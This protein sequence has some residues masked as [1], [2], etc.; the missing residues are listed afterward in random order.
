MTLVDSNVA[1]DVLT[2]DPAWLDWSVEALAKRT[3]CGALCINEVIYAE[4]S[5]RMDS[6]A[7]LEEALARLKLELTRIPR[8]AL[9]V[10]GKIFPRY[11]SCF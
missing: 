1:I 2:K 10:A 9:F 3:A 6:E 7:M 4:L 5:I 11:S 8:Q